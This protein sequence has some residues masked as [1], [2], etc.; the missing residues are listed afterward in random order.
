MSETFQR[1]A[2]AYD[3]LVGRY[4][5]PLAGELVAFAGI[6]RGM[7]ALDVG[8]GPGGLTAVLAELLGGENVAGAEPS[9][10]FAAAAR[11]R[12]PDAEIVQAA[13]EALPFDDDRFDAVLSQLV[14]NFMADAEQGVREMAR[15]A[16]PG[17][18]VASCV[19]DYT[20]GMTLLR[21]FWDAARDVE[22]ERAAGNDEGSLM[23]WTR[24]DELR[25]LWEGAGLG[26]VRTGALTV[27]V[28]Y[29]SFDEVWLPFLDGA[30]PAAA[31]AASSPDPD[32]LRDALH[33]RL[34]VPDGP[35]ELPATARAV[36][37]RAR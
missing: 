25:S 6:E 19:W 24:E 34:A 23:R 17:G 18:T 33:Q 32:R 31:F 11:E 35:F 20:G 1:P 22:P 4:S 10:Q 27:H 28:S 12:V 30:G 8:C 26:D 13:A 7:R 37:G 3:R 9:E 16:R 36:A 2:A 14:I 15:V 29:S 21:G 5:T